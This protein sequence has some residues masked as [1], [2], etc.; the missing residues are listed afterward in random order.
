[1]KCALSIVLALFL[2]SIANATI[3]DVNLVDLDGPQI[4]GQV[5]TATNRFVVTSWIENPGGLANWS[6]SPASLPLTY[7][8]LMSSGAVYDVPD[9]WDGKIDLTWGFIADA[10]N[11]DV[12]WN[13]G[14][15]TEA[16]RH[17]G[18]GGG[19][20]VATRPAIAV[21]LFTEMNWQWA[22]TG[23]TDVNTSTFDSVSVVAIPEPSTLLLA[24]V[25]LPL[26]LRRRRTTSGL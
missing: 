9:N 7:T 24:A 2:Q 19:I 22:P 17:H 12:L 15:Y 18:W 5:D 10:R 4:V 20:T 1:M 3:Y 25:G 11:A 8:A 21:S 6:P 14:A 16:G 23:A 26:L 13:E